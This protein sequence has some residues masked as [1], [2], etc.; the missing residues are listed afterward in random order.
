MVHVGM[1]IVSASQVVKPTVVLPVGVCTLG[2]SNAATSRLFC[3]SRVPQ[4]LL[5]RTGK[6]VGIGRVGAA[7]R[8]DRLCTGFGNVKVHLSWAVE[9]LGRRRIYLHVAF[10]TL[11]HIV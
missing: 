4:V 6:Q 8:Y 7:T 3:S 10:A 9:S 5:G 11:L 2:G 1:T